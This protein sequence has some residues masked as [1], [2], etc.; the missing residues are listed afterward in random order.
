MWIWFR[1]F[2]FWSPNRNPSRHVYHDLRVPNSRRIVANRADSTDET[3][4]CQWSRRTFLGST[5]SH[6]IW[7]DFWDLGVPPK[8]QTY[9][10]LIKPIGVALFWLLSEFAQVVWHEH[11]PSLS[12][13]HFFTHI[14]DLFGDLNIFC[15]PDLGSVFPI[16]VRGVATTNHRCTCA[17]KIVCG[18]SFQ[19]LVI[20]S[21]RCFRGCG[22]SEQRS[23]LQ[24]MVFQN[25]GPANH[26]LS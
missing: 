7:S 24:L 2:A 26:P 8:C 25:R 9:G 15:A 12:I 6:V 3:N 1:F 5:R 18:S 22:D 4:Q 13:L 11:V 16:I 23:Q 17:D 21:W 19:L 10:R 14:V 20:C